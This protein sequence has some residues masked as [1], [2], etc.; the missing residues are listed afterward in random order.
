M[1]IISPTQTIQKILH[2]LYIIAQAQNVTLIIY[3]IDII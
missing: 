3:V 1:T 2:H